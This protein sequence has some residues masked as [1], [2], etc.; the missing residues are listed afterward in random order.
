MISRGN[1]LHLLI[2]FFAGFALFFAVG[3]QAEQKKD[4]LRG[5]YDKSGNQTVS[6]GLMEAV[7]LGMRHN[8]QVEIAY[9]DR[10]LKKFDLAERR[11][12]FHPNITVDGELATSASRQTTDSEGSDSDYTH[13]ESRSAGVTPKVVQKLPTGGELTVNYSWEHK[14]DF[15]WSGGATGSS[16]SNSTVS[17]ED[18]RDW[19]DTGKWTVSFTQPLLKGAGMDYNTASLKKTEMDT[20]EAILGLRDNLSSE[21]ESII[22]A[23]NSL[24]SAQQ[25]YKIARKSL[26]D[27]RDQLKLNKLM[28]K[29]GRKAESELLQ[30][31]ANVARQEL[32]FENAANSLDQARTNLQ[33]VLDLPEKIQINATEEYSFQPKRPQMD[34]CLE[35]ARKQN[36]AFITAQHS[37]RRAELDL[38]QKKRDRL[39]DLSLEG[40]YEQKAAHTYDSPHDSRR[41]F[42]EVG[43]TLSIPLFK[44]GKSKYTYEK[45]LLTARIKLDKARMDLKEA[46]EDLRTEIKNKVRNVRHAVKSVKLA[47]QSRKIAQ[48]RYKMD[49]LKLRL[50]RISNNDFVDS[51]ERLSEAKRKVVENIKGYISKANSLNQYLGTLLETYNVEFKKTRP[52]VEKKYLKGKTWML[53]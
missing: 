37:V 17:G 3:V 46:K 18:P 42:W 35:I 16:S 53:D 47:R 13:K 38:M 32:S 44:W 33:D 43:L 40:K 14:T 20:R 48:K 21:L 45:D 29:T 36:T 28:V 11:R 5:K 51:Q 27:A 26:R 12:E 10:V 41:N 7:T 50:G 6:M 22:S 4:E 34:K 24:W 31:R 9:M 25:S 1:F 30:P 2:V 49:E 52:S 8:R 39:W 19:S 15:D 23:Y